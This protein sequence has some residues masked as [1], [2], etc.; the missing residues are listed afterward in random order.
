VSL[1]PR[2]ILQNLALGQALTV[3]PPLGDSYAG[4]SAQTIA[5]I[6]MML[7]AD[8]DNHAAR[9]IRYRAALLDLLGTAAPDDVAIAA[10][11]RHIVST[12]EE[13]PLA[14]R[15]DRLLQGFIL[16][17]EWADDHDPALAR[18]CRAFLADWALSE[19]LP[20][21]GVDAVVG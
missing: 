2:T 16:L 19:K 15:L 10:D 13:L 18:R 11:L 7:A 8:F 12:I 4:K 9:R 3:A 17:H 20:P 21:P 14:S 5:A 6:L 1:S